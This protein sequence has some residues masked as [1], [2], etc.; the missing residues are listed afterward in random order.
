MTCLYEAT[1]DDLIRA[2]M[3]NYRAWLIRGCSGKNPY[4]TY[5]K[6]RVAAKGE[7]LKPLANAMKSYPGAH[8]LR[9]LDCALEGS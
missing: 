7:D 9:T 4:S 3:Q 1:M 5:M 2:F 8:D 6:L